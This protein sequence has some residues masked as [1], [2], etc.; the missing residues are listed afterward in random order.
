MP[1]NGSFRRGGPFSFIGLRFACLEKLIGELLFAS[2]RQP[3]VAQQ[4][5]LELREVRVYDVGRVGD[6]DVHVVVPCEQVREIA[7]DAQVGAAQR[8]VRVVGLTRSHLLRPLVEVLAPLVVPFLESTHEG[9]LVRLGKHVRQ[10]LELAGGLR[11]WP[12]GQV[13]P[14]SLLLVELADLYW[15]AAECFQQ[16][17]P[18]VAHD[19]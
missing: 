18:S 6:A 11:L 8:L 10:P 2:A 5:R 14:H 4:P 13:L 17:A 19:A 16:A 9:L 3:V 7:P 12:G 15:D 1:M